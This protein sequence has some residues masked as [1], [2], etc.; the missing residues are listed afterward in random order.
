MLSCVCVQSLN[1]DVDLDVAKS[2]H[3]V[4][5]VC[6]NCYKHSN[7]IQLKHALLVNPSRTVS[8]TAGLLHVMLCAVSHI[9]LLSSQSLPPWPLGQYMLSALYCCSVSCDTAGW[10]G[11]WVWFAVWGL[12]P[13]HILAHAVSCSHTAPRWVGADVCTGLCWWL[14]YWG[15]VLC[16]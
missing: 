3:L 13:H 1:N 4:I 5:N 8:E 12:I 11:Q 6:D 7:T 15:H 9:Q 2:L 16:C 10:E 14:G